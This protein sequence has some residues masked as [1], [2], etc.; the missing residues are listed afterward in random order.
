MNGYYE[1]TASGS[2]PL[3]V[4][5]AKT[6]LRIETDADDDLL[7]ILITAA[8]ISAERLTNRSFITRTWRA[9]FPGSDC[10]GQNELAKNPIT[11]VTLVEELID[12]DAGTWQAVTDTRLMLTSTFAK[13][14]Y[15]EVIY[16]PI[17]APYGVRVT[18][19]GGYSVLPKDLLQALKMHVAFMYENRGDVEAVGG[20]DIPTAAKLIYRQYRILSTYG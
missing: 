5:D 18:F 13:I 9:S 10:N 4:E 12:E 14:R 1:V 19:T 8:R 2:E 15:P 7:E 16:P 6:F 20:V 3:S 11:A 17:E